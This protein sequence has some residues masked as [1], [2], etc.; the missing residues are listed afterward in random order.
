MTETRFD[1]ATKRIKINKLV[2]A[3]QQADDGNSVKLPIELITLDENVRSSIDK[4]SKEFKQLKASIEESGLLQLPVVTPTGN[5]I[6]C[7]GGHR[8]IEALKELKHTHVKCY[9]RKLESKENIV[10]AQLIENTAR[11]N[12]HPLDMAKAIKQIKDHTE[13]KLK[14][15]AKSKRAKPKFSATKVAEMIGKERKYVEQM[16]KC[17][18]WPDEAIK[19]GLS[20]NL[21]YKQIVEIS[22]KCKSDAEV[23]AYLSSLYSDE[24]KSKKGPEKNA[25]PKRQCT[26]PVF[27][28]KNRDKMLKHFKERGVDNQIQSH[29]I[30][31]LRDMKIK[32]WLPESENGV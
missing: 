16:L 6:L 9:I 24:V 1:E 5:D 26:T 32:G 23:V 21:Q 10:L 27:R 12:L 8:R 20:I 25:T 29:I 11:E 2:S 22:S 31:F 3:L 18:N 7:V 28:P 13:S 15:L 19:L 17:S 4:E 14:A 30:E